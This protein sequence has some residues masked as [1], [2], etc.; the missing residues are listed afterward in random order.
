MANGETLTAL[1]QNPQNPPKKGKLE[2]VYDFL[3]TQ[4]KF[5]VH[6]TYQ[7]FETAMQN[8]GK[9]QKVY[10]Y[11]KTQP[12][13]KN[14]P[15]T[16]EGF[17]DSVVK[18][19][20]VQ[21]P[22]DTDQ[23]SQQI[24]ATSQAQDPVQEF[25]E[26]SQE[27]GKALSAE[28]EVAPGGID[29]PTP[30]WAT[31]KAAA[32]SPEMIRQRAIEERTISPE[33]QAR[34]LTRSIAEEQELEQQPPGALE[35]VESA[36]GAFNRPVVELVSSLPKTSGLIINQ[37]D[38]LLASIQGKEKP[39]VETNP[40]YQAGQ[41]LDD[42]ALE[43]GITAT[44]PKLDDSFFFSDVPSAFGSAFAIMMSGGRSG[45]GKA[46][47][48]K[49][50]TAPKGLLG[51]TKV[52]AQE[53]GKTLASRPV[54]AG[55][56]M[57]GTSEYE[58]AIAAGVPEEEAFGVFLKNYAIG[59]TEAIPIERY[60][61]RINKL[62]GGKIIDVIKAGGV[63]SIEEAAQEGMQNYLTNNV[64]RGTYDPQR[65]PFK[66][67]IRSMG[68]GAFVGFFLPGIGKAMEKMTPE[69]REATKKELNEAFKEVAPEKAEAIE[70]SIQTPE[71]LLGEEEGKK[72]EGIK[73]EVPAKEETK[74]QRGKG[75]AAVTPKA[76]TDE[77]QA[78]TDEAKAEAQRVL[79]EETQQPAEGKEA[80][81]TTTEE[82][83]TEEVRRPSE[84]LPD[85]FKFLE[86]KTL[87]KKIDLPKWELDASKL[88]GDHVN[89]S[90]SQ[91][92]QIKQKQTDAALSKI[93]IS[94]ERRPAMNGVF[95][96]AENK[97]KTVTNGSSLVIIPDK[98][99]K[100]T[101][102]VH[103]KTG[104]I[105]DDKFPDYRNVIPT[106]IY[107]TE[108]KD[109]NDLRSRIGSINSA[110]KLLKSDPGILAEIKYGSRYIYVNA[111]LLGDAID[112]LLETGS[113][114]LSF[115]LPTKPSKGIIIRDG[116]NPR[117]LALIMP[118]MQ[119]DYT[120][121][122][123]RGDKEG[124]PF[125]NIFEAD[126]FN[127]TDI[128]EAVTAATKW[129]FDYHTEE[130]KK[131]V[132]EK[133]EWGQEYHKKK[134][135]EVLVEREKIKKDLREELKKLKDAISKQSTAKVPVRKAPTDSGAVEEGKPQPGPEEAAGEEATVQ[136]EGQPATTQEG[137]EIE[138]A[139]RQSE[140]I[141]QEVEFERFG[142]TKKG[143]VLGT[144][145]RGK[146]IIQDSE[147][148]KFRVAPEEVKELGK[149][150]VKK[151]K[152]VKPAATKEEIESAKPKTEE[153]IVQYKSPKK[154]Q[155]GIVGSPKAGFSFGSD[156][157]EKLVE[158]AGPWIKKQFTSK[159]Y[160]PQ[161]VF[162]RW[163]K[164]KGETSKYEAQVR[165]TVGDIKKA[166]K[167]EY[168]GK[169]TDEQITD[170]NLFLQGKKPVNP[171]PAKTKALLSDMRAQVDNLSRRFINEGVISGDLTATFTDNLGTY[172]TRSY[173]KF[174]DPF[175]AE[176]VDPKVRTN[177]EGFIRNNSIYRGQ[178]ILARATRLRDRE[179]KKAD[180]IKKLEEE[181]KALSAPFTKKPSARISPKGVKRVLSKN[182]EQVKE[183][184]KR[185]DALKNRDFLAEAQ[186]LEK[187]A[188]QA[189]NVTPQEIEGLINFLL[190]D[191][192]APT[193]I[194]KGVKLGSKD[195]SILKKRGEI[196]PEIRALM[197]EYSDPLL[198]YAR[199]IT[200]MSN[201]IAKHHF[202]QDVKAEGMGQFLFKDK[203]GEYFVPIAAEGSKTMAPLNGL[204]T[205]K[206]IA[207]AFND[208]NNLEPTNVFFKAWL[209]IN[210][211]IKSGK[212]VF[213]A[214]THARNFF[215]N[216]G[217]VVMNGHWRL[218]KFGKAA[219]TA[220]ANVYSN[221][222]AIR[223]KF[224]EYLELGV[225]QDSGAAGELK[226][227]LEDIRAGRDFFESINENRLN[228]AKRTILETSQNLYQFEDDLYKVF[229]F[230]NEY[231]RYKKAMP[232]A[233]DQQVKEKAAKI[234]RD[235]Y[236]TYS[237]VPKIVKAFR[238]NPLVGSFVSFPAEVLRTTYNTIALAKEELSNPSTR[239][240]GIQRSTGI[241]LSM[242]GTSAASYGTMALLGL[243][244]E[245]DE[246]IR[247]FVAPWQR[248]SEFLY[249]K[250]SGDKWKIIDMGYSDPHSYIKRP[251]YNLFKGD[252]DSLLDD[253]AQ[254]SWSL[255]EPFLSEEILTERMIDFSRNQKK[256]GDHVYNPDGDLGDKV[257]DTFLHFYGGAEIGTMSS[258]RRIY[259]AATDETNVYGQKYE[260]SNEVI[261][262]MFGM[263]E[264]TKDITQSL[265]YRAYDFRDRISATQKD[266]YRVTKSASAS[267]EDKQEAQR[268]YDA[269]VRRIKT[270]AVATYRAA[271]RLGVDPKQARRTMYGTKSKE[272]IKAIKGSN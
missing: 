252:T 195:L 212:T 23:L 268:K 138:P 221:N 119:G 257:T 46:G 141:G 126:S 100:N 11:L 146:V 115:E 224:K 58:Q 53:L 134:I 87:P 251:F 3:K 211:Y 92:K 56:L 216:L 179:I 262:L 226:Q 7:E 156:T 72:E 38:R 41:W 153:E 39:D 19:K 215:G 239:A 93:T 163:I 131:A 97:V 254:A 230:E 57:M 68:A 213:S 21:L 47:L 191:P 22:T 66:D 6:D 154:Q 171:I 193:S 187:Q 76:K 204:Y 222:Q 99:I 173:R 196:A 220:W 158:K 13:V 244:G 40:L 128:D 207:E 36:A 113:K 219:Q 136:D 45:V 166:I 82:T 270:D 132:K 73:E 150:T 186:E 31:D 121:S 188:K 266:L 164:T 8:E 74:P 55:G 265:L 259:K 271:I 143:K 152:K 192:K 197:G 70:Q 48:E 235:T 37:M 210:G 165:F 135:N 20:E 205:T 49:V 185:L 86:E 200:K 145:E 246:D 177:A 54:V 34:Q 33:A 79:T 104:K 77:G 127:I 101:R 109:V 75:K 117:K 149:K 125:T 260:L 227:Y 182:A 103:P 43:V 241:L 35:S 242:F 107:K 175:W 168:K 139:V 98:S 243:D 4:E 30:L 24:M 63:G 258:L 203:T 81:V 181:I 264:E 80:A 174:D 116:G 233:T 208:F 155:I 61:S 105:I 209:K 69:Q 162:D 249:T 206:E 234:V 269:A 267:P 52:A 102:I 64:A 247:K 18:K 142:K 237:M 124:M 199:T 120:E 111:K 5:K 147:G 245:D 106:N 184:Q 236:P 95:Y 71:G 67:M 25:L 248:D 225:V 231:A 256:N 28:Y 17:R 214:M 78:Q 114:K 27:P 9:L 51:N 32:E 253:A 129:D 170:M 161:Y 201:L 223:D 250:V 189:I 10:E 118:T 167:Q 42:K 202:L 232:N 272:I 238:A 198:N 62:S 108:I 26:A 240:I 110:N 12:R 133:S 148:I 229:A 88:G 159:G 122:T 228:K 183:L 160:L 29:I 130:Y 94:D 1:S 59:Q 178:R 16:F 123:Q 89:L 172:L 65:E 91:P 190:Y 85:K 44:N 169:P 194:L 261:G 176:F 157:I 255:L 14:V 84:T 2:K 180:V 144:D 50:I 137:Q 60:L 96:D 263:K 217:F 151:K 15:P 140:Q 112:T 218:D 83:K 90:P